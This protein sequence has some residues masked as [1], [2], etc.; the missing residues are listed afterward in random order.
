[1]T[2]DDVAKILGTSQTMCSHYETGK[3]ELPVRHL[4]ELCKRYQVSADYILG[5][6]NDPN[7]ANLKYK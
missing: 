1:M 4:I 3:V 2:Q 7:P 5:F 6:T